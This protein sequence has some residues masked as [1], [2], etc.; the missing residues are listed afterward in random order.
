MDVETERVSLI[1]VI[2]S[3]LTEGISK[4]V[5]VNNVLESYEEEYLA[6]CLMFL[7]SHVLHQNI[8]LFKEE[9]KPDYMA[10]SKDI[11]KMKDID[12][13]IVFKLGLSTRQFC[14]SQAIKTFCIT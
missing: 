8:C 1:S 7:L 2:N 6:N 10:I 11:R 14:M 3:F 12:F 13:P 9:I 4:T 5:Q